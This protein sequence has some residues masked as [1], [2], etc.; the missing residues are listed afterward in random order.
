MKIASLAPLRNKHAG[1]PWYVCTPARFAQSGKRERRFFLTET[2]AKKY[3]KLELRRI[4]REGHHK[5]A[6]ITAA[7]REAAAAAFRLIPDEQPAKIIEIVEQ[8][9]ARRELATKSEKLDDVF[10]RYIERGKKKRTRGG[11]AAFVPFSKKH[12]SGIEYAKRQLEAHKESKVSEIT[13]KMIEASL[14]PC[15]ASYFNAHLR[16]IRAVF[17][18]A[19]DKKWA[20]ENPAAGIEPKTGAIREAS[21]EILTIKQTENLLRTAAEAAPQYIPFLALSL[22]AGI[23]PD[24]DDGELVKMTWDMVH[25]KD[26][27]IIIPANVSKTGD[28]RVIEMEDTLAD[29]LKYYVSKNKSPKGAIAPKKNIITLMRMLRSIAGVEWKQDIARHSFASYHLTHFENLARCV[30]SM[31]HRDA[32]M[33]W[34]HYHAAVPKDVAAAYWKITPKSLGLA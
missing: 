29:W 7:Q 33:L 22:F 17:E 6:E 30:A 2:E 20:V 31:G 14:A 4:E 28:R 16:I 26:R 9:K 11:M 1:P 25:L 24:L 10:E 12:K 5:G 13:Q 3:A 34:K 18:Y 19:V 27:R 32:Q 21:A 23:R 15:S 8:W